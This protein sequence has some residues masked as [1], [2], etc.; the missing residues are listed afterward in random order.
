MN[1]IEKS[2]KKLPPF[3]GWVLQNFP[4]IEE[5]FDAITNYQMMC[6]VIEYLKVIQNNVDYIQDEEFTPLYNAFVELK[7]YV[8]NYFENLDVQE[9]VNNKL[10]EMAESGELAELISQYLSLSNLFAFDTIADMSEN[11]YLTNGLIVYTAGKDTYDDG[12]Y[13][14]YKIRELRVTDVID[15]YNIVALTNSQTLIAERLPND[16]VTSMQNEINEFEEEV[17]SGLVKNKIFIA[18]FFDQ[19]TEHVHLSTSLDGENFSD[20]LP[21]I[22]L[23]GRDPQIIYNPNTKLFYLSVTWGQNTTDTDFTM[24]VSSDLINWETKHI[25]LGL[26]NNLRWAPELFIDS[27]GTMYCFI[28]HG[29]DTDHMFIYKSVCTDI[30]NL[31]F[32]TAL[33]VTLDES[34]MIDANIIKDNDIYY[35]CVKN[36]TTAKELIYASNDLTNWSNINRDILKS[37]EHCEG[38]M[39]LKINDKFNFYG[40]TWQSFGYYIKGQTEDL[41][42]FNSFTRPNS[43][44]GKRHGS[45]TYITDPS[46][47]NLITSLESYTNNVNE[48]RSASREYDLNGTIDELVI[49]PNF[50]YRITATTTINKLINAYNLDKFNFYFATNNSATL[51]VT[52][53]I[54]NEY[55]EKTV[56]FT[57]YNSR[58]ENEKMNYISLIGNPKLLRNANIETLNASN[59]ITMNTGWSASWYS[60]TRYGDYI[61]V[62]GDIKRTS[63][64]SARAFTI[65][66]YLP[67]YHQFY[68][69]NKSANTMHL[70]NNGNC[71]I[72]GTIPDNTNI[73][74]SF[75]YY[76]PR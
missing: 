76:S 11:E 14:Y 31:T 26:L 9:E 46:A 17:E 49:Y 69:T 50:I 24:Y 5:D 7:N 67:L 19:A 42:N 30:E 37:G 57:V 51:T 70:Y 75:E 40:D 53:I 71:D 8:D 25:N 63:G 41:S 10:D 56:N 73:F 44:I 74:V 62:D 23:E 38:G 43:L 58:A 47:I 21:D 68:A 27:D 33:P 12:K 60:M 34:N 35:M 22:N 2:Y 16:Y 1:N 29:V 28:S 59:Y 61:H 15:G 6:K 36:N 32:S 13:G 66:S 48:N 39:I 3:K 72:Q 54:N 65:A 55:Q 52:K 18:S 45:I 20:I 64:T 4:F